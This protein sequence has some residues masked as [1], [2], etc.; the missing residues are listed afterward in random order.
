MFDPHDICEKCGLVTDGDCECPEKQRVGYFS[1]NLIEI[2]RHISEK[3]KEM[4]GHI[5]AAGINAYE[6]EMLSVKLEEGLNQ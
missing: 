3:T 1:S 5:E 2:S 6:I 4:A